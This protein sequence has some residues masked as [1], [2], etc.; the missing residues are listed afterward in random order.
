LESLLA[1]VAAHPDTTDQRV[2]LAKETQQE[3]I[4]LKGNGFSESAWSAFFNKQFF[5]RLDTC[6]LSSN[7]ESR[8]YVTQF[9]TY[10]AWLN[11]FF[12]LFPKDLPGAISIMMQL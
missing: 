8:V 7:P 5:H 10:S 6:T 9:Q 3:A 11:F 2:R 4:R 12:L 1:H